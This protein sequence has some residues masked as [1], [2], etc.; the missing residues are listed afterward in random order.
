M[1]KNERFTKP[2]DTWYESFL[3]VGLCTVRKLL[4]ESSDQVYYYSSDLIFRLKDFI[5][6]CSTVNNRLTYSTC[7]ISGWRMSVER[8]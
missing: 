8:V 4:T 7:T 1:P 3:K 5:L 2:T 6:E